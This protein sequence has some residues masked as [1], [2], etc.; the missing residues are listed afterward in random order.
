[1]LEKSV[2]I[3]P[4]YTDARWELANAYLRVGDNAN[5]LKHFELIARSK[6]KQRKEEAL[7]YIELLRVR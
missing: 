3:A 4:F 7:K 6:D 1:M 2:N 5:A